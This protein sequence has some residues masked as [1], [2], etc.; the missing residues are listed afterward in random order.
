[1]NVMRELYGDAGVNLC[2]ELATRMRKHT[3]SKAADARHAAA[4]AYRA[5]GT[6]ASDALKHAA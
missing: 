6:Y 3:Q 1:M 5:P 2:N 4:P